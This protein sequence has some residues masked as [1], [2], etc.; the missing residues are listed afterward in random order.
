MYLII[1]AQTNEDGTTAKCVN[2]TKE[3]ILEAGGELEVINLNKIKLEGCRVCGSDGWGACI[4]INSCIIKDELQKIQEKTK[5]CEGLFLIT[6]VYWSQPSELMKN[7]MDR[8][9]RC[10]A[11][12][13]GGSWLTGKVVNMVANAGGG[14]N[15]A[16]PCLIEM[17]NWAHHLGAKS[18]ERISV[19]KLNI[20]KMKEVIK[21]VAFRTVNGDYLKK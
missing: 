13:E 2:A 9:R 15:G 14:G 6:P 17:E 4:K 3:G 10:E 8:Y 20:N 1:S 5:A 11:F 21:D 18:K 16:I 19:N 12:R 7:F